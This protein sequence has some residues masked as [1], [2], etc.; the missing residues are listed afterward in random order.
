MSSPVDEGVIQAMSGQS[1]RR[2][3]NFQCWINIMLLSLTSTQPSHERWRKNAIQFLQLLLNAS[4]TLSLSLTPSLSLFLSPKHWS[5]FL[6]KVKCEDDVQTDVRWCVCVPVYVLQENG[7]FYGCLPGLGGLSGG[8][9][10][11]WGLLWRTIVPGSRGGVARARKK[12][13]N[14]ASV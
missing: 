7:I 13:Q 11:S 8:G 3:T 6:P 14:T 10:C 2:K 5:A 4:L 1:K 12:K 9:G